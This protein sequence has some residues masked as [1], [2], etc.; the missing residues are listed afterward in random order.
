M[1]E[2]LSFLGISEIVGMTYERMSGSKGGSVE[3]LIECDR[4]ARR[5]A[6]ELIER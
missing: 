3:A 5:I 2:K 4:E 1:N 6:K